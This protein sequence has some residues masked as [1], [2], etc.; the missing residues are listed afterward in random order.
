MAIEMIMPKVEKEQETGTIL[1]WLRTEGQ[2]VKEGE[3]ILVIETDKIAIDIESPGTGTLAGISAHPGDVIPVGSVIAYI[4]AEGEELPESTSQIPTTSDSAGREAPVSGKDGQSHPSLSG[5]QIPLT[6]MRRTIAERLN[7]SYR[8]IP[9]IQFSGGVDMTNFNK[10]RKH[11]NGLSIQGGASKV[12]VTAMLVKLV[13]RTLADHPLLNSSLQ[14]EVI[15]LHKEINIGVAV[16]LEDGLI[17][18]VIRNA[19]KKDIREI[20]AESEDMISRARKGGLTSA[21]V[22]GTTFTISNLG[23]FGIEQFNAIINPPEV[24]VLAIGATLPKVIPLEGGEIAVRPYMRFTLST[25][26]RVVDGAVAAR[27]L[28]DLKANLEDPSIMDD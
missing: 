14:N 21:D 16:A 10:V 25:D 5:G 23:P 20:A 19:D 15:I 2:G 1:E 26:H 8:T 11:L 17:V 4:L 3:I 22:K 6:G 13:A 28:A 18:P 24:C 12:S 27:F 9:H 7:A